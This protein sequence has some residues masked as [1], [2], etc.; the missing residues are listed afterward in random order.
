[1]T[2]STKDETV[3]AYHTVQERPEAVQASAPVAC[4]TEN[5]FRPVDKRAADTRR[6]FSASASRQLQ[7]LFGMSYRK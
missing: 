2:F 7:R 5:Y 4:G 6:I 1:M 3:T